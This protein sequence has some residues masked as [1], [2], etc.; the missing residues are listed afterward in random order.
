MNDL[1][2]TLLQKYQVKHI[3]TTAYHPEG[4]GLTERMNQT[5]KN[6]IS[7]LMQTQGGEWDLYVDSALFAIRTMKQDSTRFTPFELTYARKAR[8]L[9]SI[10]QTSMTHQELLDYRVNN[11]IKSI[12]D[13]RNQAAEFISLAQERQKRNY[14]KEYKTPEKLKIGD[15]VLL[16]RSVTESSWSAKLEPK[17]EGPFLIRTINGTTYELMR[18]TG[19]ILPYKVHRNRL[20]KYHPRPPDIID[21]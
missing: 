4:N 13:V 6:T 17:W 18:P 1:I 8:Q 19:T 3:T 2:R 9:E 7:K 10:P 11:E 14:D 20:K 21:C 12:K 15:H 16:F 5:L